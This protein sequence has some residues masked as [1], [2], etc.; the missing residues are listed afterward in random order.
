MSTS[1]GKKKGFSTAYG[2][3]SS[4]LDEEGTIDKNNEPSGTISLSKHSVDRNH[5]RCNPH[6]VGYPSETTDIMMDTTETSYSAPVKN[7]EASSTAPVRKNEYI[8]TWDRADNNDSP[9]VDEHTPIQDHKESSPHVDEWKEKISNTLSDISS[10]KKNNSVMVL[11]ICACVATVLSFFLPLISLS[12]FVTV[13]QS[14]FDYAMSG[15][16]AIL[17][18]LLLSVVGLVCAIVAHKNAKIAAGTIVT[19]LLSMIVMFVALSTT[20]E[21]LRPIDYVASGFYVYM[22]SHFAAMVLAAVS[23]YL[24]KF[25][26]A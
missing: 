11:A 4:H 15:E 8:A 26:K 12:F 9:V 5:S 22:I 7:T 20:E 6:Y 17:I 3:N 13:S 2:S 18:C 25:S 24:T 23:L 1:N 21:F 10:G 14:G 19:S 16:P